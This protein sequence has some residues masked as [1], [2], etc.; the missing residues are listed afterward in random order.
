[1][2][3]GAVALL[4]VIEMALPWWLASEV[5]ASVRAGV[6][7]IPLAIVAGVVAALVLHD[8]RSFSRWWPWLAASRWHSLLWLGVAGA[9]LALDGV[10]PWAA[11]QISLALLVAACCMRED[12]VLMPLLRLAPMA[13]LGSISYGLYLLHMLCKNAVQ[14]G[15]GAIGLPLGAFALFLATTAV[16]IVVAGASFR[17]F[18]S[19]FLG[20]KGRFER[21]VVAVRP[22]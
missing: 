20:L 22:V 1:G 10:L 8:E 14:K 17:W 5:A 12:H 3:C 9:C 2:G 16:T 18:E 11:L 13:Y 15:A 7:K 4:A 19:R 21:N 6:H